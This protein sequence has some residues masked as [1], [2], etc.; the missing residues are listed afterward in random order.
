VTITQ[1]RIMEATS[2]VIHLTGR[3]GPWGFQPLFHA[4]LVS[5]TLLMS[6][7]RLQDRWI[8]T[9]LI[10]EL[11][12]GCMLPCISP[13]ALSS[14]TCM[15]TATIVTETLPSMLRLYTC[16]GNP[17]LWGSISSSSAE[18]YFLSSI[19]ISPVSLLARVLEPLNFY[20]THPSWPPML[21]PSIN[22]WIPSKLL[23][24]LLTQLTHLLRLSASRSGLGHCS[25]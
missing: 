25:S 7:Y 6:L 5:Y 24:S 11:E 19:I 18:L 1:P 17:A 13:L 14:V 12:A 16:P 20:P 2:S 9:F 3:H 23:D 10:P 21:E 4:I 15:R 8:R 22:S